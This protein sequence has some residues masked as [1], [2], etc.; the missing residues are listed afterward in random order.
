MDKCDIGIYGLGIMGQNLAINF[1]NQG[2]AVSVFNRME[3]GEEN[4]VDSFIVNRCQGKKIIGAGNI[5][6][7]VNFIKTPRKIIVLVKAGTAVDEVI[8]KLI[9]FLEV[10]DIIID[11]SNSHYRDTARRLPQLESRGLLFVGCGISGGG[12][13]ALN[14]PSIMPGGSFRAWEK[15]MSLLQAVAAKCEDGDPCCDWIGPEGSGHFVK[16]VHNGIEYALM[17]ILAESYDVMKRMLSMSTDEINGVVSAWNEGVLHSYLLGITNDILKMIDKDD[18]PL[19]ENILDCSEQK[20]TGKDISISSLEL[21]VPATA[22]NES[23]NARFISCMI[24]ERQCASKEFI[25]PEQFADD[26]QVLLKALHDA[27]YCSQFIVYAQGFLLIVRGSAEYNWNVDLT[28]I[29]RIWKNGCIIQSDILNDIAATLKRRTGLE[30]ILLE[31]YFVKIINRKQINWRHTIITA[32]QHGIPIPAMSSALTYFDSF[33]SERLP[34]NLIQAQRDYFGA[35]GF[36]RL[37]APRG[38]VFHI[39]KN[40]GT[41]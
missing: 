26:K 13:G 25:M 3:A 30:N 19:V 16:M 11:G 40:V 6:E 39:R 37:D 33:R 35:H 21:D 4:V 18:R 38:V 12:E 9:S 24:N 23:I 34:A 2:F 14:G 8:D 27:I 5:K 10:D 36:E 41:P 17:Q 22:I 20:G 7:F 15:I 1:A 32:I 28:K 29:A 31:P